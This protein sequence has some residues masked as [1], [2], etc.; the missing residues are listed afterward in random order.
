[1]HRK[2]S[3]IYIQIS[4]SFSTRLFSTFC[5]A[6]YCTHLNKFYQLTLGYLSDKK[7]NDFL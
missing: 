3:E 4:V 6:V 2:L 5:V 1:M 7:L